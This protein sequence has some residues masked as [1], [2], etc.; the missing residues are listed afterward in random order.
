MKKT[1]TKTLTRLSADELISL[2]DQVRE[3]IAIEHNIPREKKFTN[4]DLWNIQRCVR[5]TFIRRY[6]TL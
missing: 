6:L 2:T 3:T 4:I 5:S 1:I